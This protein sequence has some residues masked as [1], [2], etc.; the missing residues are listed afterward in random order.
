VPLLFGRLTAADYEDD[1][2][3]DDRIDALRAK[4]KCVEEPSFTV[5]YHDPEK[6]SIANSLWIE[7]SDGTALEETVEY[8]LGHKRRR[9]EGI[10][11]LEAKFRRNLARR[12]LH[13]QQQKILD[14][15]LDQSRLEGMAV[16]DYVDLYVTA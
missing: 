5:D 10:P 2:A 9:A 16:N 14:A 3:A 1:V 4:M 6:R 15:S 11:L 13:A 8:P 7:L 12:Y